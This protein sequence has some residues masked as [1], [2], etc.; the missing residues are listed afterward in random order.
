MNLKSN[1]LFIN[2]NGGNIQAKFNILYL[3][4]KI[5]YLINNIDQIHY[6]SMNLESQI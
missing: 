5:I 1:F 2:K 3:L 6:F 4:K